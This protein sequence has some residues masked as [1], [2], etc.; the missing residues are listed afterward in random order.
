MHICKQW[1]IKSL[2]D[3]LIGG[4][5]IGQLVCSTETLGGSDTVWDGP[6]S[7]NEIQF[8]Y[9]YERK[10]FV[11]YS[12]E[13]IFSTTTR[14]EL[15]QGTTNSILGEIRHI[16]DEAIIMHPLI[17]GAPTYDHPEN[18]DFIDQLIWLGWDQY[19]V[20]PEDVL[21]FSRIK[22]VS[23]NPAGEWMNQMRILAEKDVKQKLTE[24][25]GDLSKKDWGGEQ[26]DH[27][28]SNLTLGKKRTTAAFLLKGPARFEEMQP[29]HLG[30]NADQI[31][32]LASSP[33]NLLVV[34][35]CHDIGE[36][37]RATLRAFAV[38][39]HNPRYYCLIDGKD[40]YRLLRAYEKI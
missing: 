33:A 6:R 21:E 22:E 30:K 12:T 31:Y 20:F 35:H 14:G 37:V 24:I 9:E 7:S 4:P 38:T 13:H 32:R 23:L 1:G 40:T 19:E 28:S 8:P 2:A 27:F 29:K 16:T 18:K 15:A 10:V 26:N 34:Q 5:G 3:A 17:I 11:K 39:P 36:A 25:L